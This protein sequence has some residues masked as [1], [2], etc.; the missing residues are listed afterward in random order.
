MF[1]STLCGTPTGTILGSIGQQPFNFELVRNLKPGQNLFL[2]S[3]AAPRGLGC[4]P[5]VSS[6]WRPEKQSNSFALVGSK[7]F[8]MKLGDEMKLEQGQY[9]Q[10]DRDSNGNIERIV[11]FTTDP[12]L[13]QVPYVDQNGAELLLVLQPKTRDLFCPVDQEPDKQI[14]MLEWQQPKPGFG[15]TK[16]G[17][18]MSTA[19]QLELE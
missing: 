13:K 4:T 9:Y 18:F 7:L 16:S 1:N 6:F 2:N 10:I 14:F 12:S 15:L 19:P 17:S 5:S 8:A 11:L 3:I